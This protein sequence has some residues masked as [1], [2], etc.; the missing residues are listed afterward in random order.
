M[1]K[2]KNSKAIFKVQ[3]RFSLLVR[4]VPFFMILINLDRILLFVF[5][6]TNF[7]PFHPLPAPHRL[8]WKV[9]APSPARLWVA[10]TV[11][12]WV[13]NSHSRGQCYFK[14][15]PKL[16]CPICL[17]H[18]TELCDHGQPVQSLSGTVCV[19]AQHDE[20]QRVCMDPE[21]ACVESHF[22]PESGR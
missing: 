4:S 16:V 7:S 19:P 15:L 9:R 22:Q 11:G 17:K 18:K 20:G 3:W 10:L 13:L 14:N 2:P 8:S 5:C 12:L 6:L 1:T 21:T